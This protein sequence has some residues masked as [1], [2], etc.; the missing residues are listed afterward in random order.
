MNFPLIEAVDW[1]E[2]SNKVDYYQVDI[3]AK[4]NKIISNRLA[5]CLGLRKDEI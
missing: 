5:K 4:L 3:Y 2:S 1:L